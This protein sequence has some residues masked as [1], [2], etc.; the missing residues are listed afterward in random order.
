MTDTTMS[1]ESGSR[2]CVLC[3]YALDGLPERHHCPEC[4]QAY[5]ERSRVFEKGSFS[6]LTIGLYAFAVFSMTRRM[7]L[8]KGQQG[9]SWIRFSIEFL[10]FSFMMIGLIA[11]VIERI[12]R[13]G[14]PQSIS[15]LPE[16]LRMQIDGDEIAEFPWDEI[17]TVRAVKGFQKT[18]PVID[19]ANGKKKEIGAFFDKREEV[20]AFVRLIRHRLRVH[21]R[22]LRQQDDHV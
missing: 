12:Q 17:T 21:R 3:K 9:A 15:V 5:D 4:G 7:T 22:E 11:W 1:S 20:I 13:W 10:L 6:W 2:F 19:F 18:Y 8:F 16:R 14:Q